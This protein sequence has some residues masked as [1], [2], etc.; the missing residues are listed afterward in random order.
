MSAYSFRRW[1]FADLHAFMG[2]RF[3]DL[4]VRHWQEAGI[5]QGDMPLDIDI[6]QYHKLEQAGLLRTFVACHDGQAVGYAQYF[7]APH[8]HYRTTCWATGDTF[9]IAPEHRSV[10]TALGLFGFAEQCLR[11]DGAKFM[12]TTTEA[13]IP[14]AGKVL[15]R[16]GHVA[17]EIAYVKAL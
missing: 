9:Y 2:E 7:V 12:H 16:L 10:F 13:H 14:G 4:P 17:T 1:S 8:L 6:A 11:E 3:N 15:E 5:M